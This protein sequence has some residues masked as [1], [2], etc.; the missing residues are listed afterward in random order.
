MDK[1]LLCFLV[2][3]SGCCAFTSEDCN[4][5]PPE[6]ELNPEVLEWIAPYDEL[7]VFMFEDGAGNEDSFLVERLMDEE[8]CGGDECGTDCQVEIAILTSTNTPGLSLRLSGAN[9]NDFRINNTNSQNYFAGLYVRDNSSFS[10]ED[11]IKV[12]YE[13]AYEWDGTT[14]PALSINCENSIGCFDFAFRT[15]VIFLKTLD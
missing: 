10:F 15:I 9:I 12:S 2:L 4:C 1:L 3:L 13:E 11:E 6:P 7:E 5:T 8:F 14:T